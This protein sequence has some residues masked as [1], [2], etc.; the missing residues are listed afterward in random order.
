MHLFVVVVVV[1]IITKLRRKLRFL[2]TCI[3]LVA[4]QEVYIHRSCIKED[5]IK[6]FMGEDSHGLAG[7][8][9]IHERGKVE[10]GR[11]KMLPGTSSP[12]FGSSFSHPQLSATKRKSQQYATTIRRASERPLVG[13]WC[14][15]SKE[16]DTSQSPFQRLSWYRA[17]LARNVST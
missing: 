10:E 6:V 17:F 9:V 2:H 8:R 11:V 1:I 13:S 16:R 4:L 15:A 3:F 5:L 12:P 14:L 7:M